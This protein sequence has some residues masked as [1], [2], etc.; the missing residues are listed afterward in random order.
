MQQQVLPVRRSSTQYELQPESTHSESV[1]HN[2]SNM[3]I[4]SNYRQTQQHTNTPTTEPPDITDNPNRISTIPTTSIPQ[5]SRFTMN[6]SSLP[7]QQAE[8]D[9]LDRGLTFIP[10]S[11]THPVQNIYTLCNRLI[12][13]IKLKDYFADEE[14]DGTFDPTVPTFKKPSQW[15][16][17]NSSLSQPTLDTINRIANSTQR[18]LQRRKLIRGKSIRLLQQKQNLSTEE[19]HIL[20]RITKNRNIVIKP[21][22][23]G[24]SVVVMDKQAYIREAY[25]QLHDTRY[26]R[27]IPDPLIKQ[28]SAR[29]Q[30]ILDDMLQQEYI[31]DKQHAYLSPSDG[32]RL[33]RFYLLPKIHKPVS[34]WPEPNIMPHGRPVVSDCNSESNRIAQYITQFLKPIS[35]KHPAYLKDTYD[36]VHKIRDKQIPKTAILVTGDVTSLYTNMNIDRMLQVTKSAFQKF[37]DASRPDDHILEL[38]NHILHNNDFQFNE[39]TFLQICGTAMGKACSPQLADLYLEWFDEQARNG[40]HVKPFLYFRYLDDVFMIWTGTV[41]QLK[42]FENFLNSLIPGIYIKLE[43]STVSISFLDTT[44]YTQ[45][46]EDHKRI[47]TK[48]YFKPTDTHQLLHKQSF[49]PKHFFTGVLKSQFIRF[50]RIS[51]T[52]NDYDEASRTLMTALKPRGYSPRKMRGLKNDI[53]YNHT[54]RTYQKQQEL[55]PIVVPYNELGIQLS[56]RWNRYIRSNPN[57]QHLKI[58]TAYTVGSNLASRLVH[59]LLETTQTDNLRQLTI[60]MGTSTKPRQECRPCH[61][62]RCKAC[63]YV[64]STHKFSN[65]VTGQNYNIRS[66]INCRTCNLVYL[67]NCTKCNLQYVGQTSRELGTRTIE[68][69]SAIRRHTDTPVAK[70]FNLPDHQLGHFRITGID[71]MATSD[72]NTA[73]QIREMYWMTTLQTIHPNGLNFIKTNQ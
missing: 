46:E 63:L 43:Y 26:Y 42:E 35:N 17:P 30:Q 22:D 20:K 9:I 68:H 34:T 2:N 64:R 55:L 27:K 8:L 16:P 48:V 60:N 11:T 47:Q 51:S 49:H 37:P 38:L 72:D 71:E 36:F 12:R 66:R 56:M 6:L 39:E 14:Q 32:D 31:D 59:S 45:E 67:V 10:T 13:N 15:S 33:R 24:S 61:H 58:I 7:L 65:M 4:Q 21:A 29:I 54:D 41:E 44:I 3:E 1:N 50:K 73:R 28:N 52:K 25:R 53:W 18:L 69:I 70:H 40:F 23:K 5:K 57:L 19:R 62:Y